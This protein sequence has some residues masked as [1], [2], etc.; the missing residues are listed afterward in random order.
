LSSVQCSQLGVSAVSAVRVQW[1]CSESAVWVQCECS[2]CSECSESAVWVQ[3]ECSEC[4]VS[5][6]WVQWAQWAQCGAAEF[7]HE[8]KQF[9]SAEAVE[10]RE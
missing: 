6:V 1:E 2:E 8:V 9:R 3:C 5:A 4:S 10:V 7:V